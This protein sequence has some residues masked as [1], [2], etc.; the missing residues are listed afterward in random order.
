MTIQELLDKLDIDISNPEA[1]KGATAAL[2][3]L[4]KGTETWPPTPPPPPTDPP[5]PQPQQKSDI[6]DKRLPRKPGNVESQDVGIADIDNATKR[7]ITYNRTL[8]AA[9]NALEK[10][11]KSGVDAEK[12]K[13]L[14]DAIAALEQ[15]T[16][17]VGQRSIQD[18]SEDE[19]DDLINNTITAIVALGQIDDELHVDTEE[20]H[21]AKVQRLADIIKD[22]SIL[23]DLENDDAYERNRDYERQQNLARIADN[24]SS[25]DKKIKKYN[26]FEDFTNSLYKAILRQVQIAETE[27]DTWTAVNRKYYDSGVVKQGSR[28]YDTPSDKIPI[29]DFYFDTS[30]SWGSADLAMG[31]RAKAV[32]RHLESKGKIV[33][34]TFYFSM[35]VSPEYSAVAGGGTYCWGDILKNIEKTNPSNVI[36]MTDSDMNGQGGHY[37]QKELKGCVWYLWK[38][39]YD[40]PNITKDLTGKKGTMQ[41]AFSSKDASMA[42]DEDKEKK[43]DL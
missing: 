31:K 43:D 21:A 42:Y 6:P 17:S 3:A 19:F 24:K 40:A 7:S 2:N 4:K 37:G 8:E 39:G 41:F 13:S 34:N 38:N 30:A 12:I 10:A 27:E 28:I 26:G 9:K 16:E 23:A 5:L 18:L 20:E 25:Y 36:I 35:G 29:I 22:D 1:V 15:L 32:L 14:K 33:L 11:E